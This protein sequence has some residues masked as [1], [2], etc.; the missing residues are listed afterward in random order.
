[1]KAF[2]MQLTLTFPY[3]AP[4]T[5]I[6]SY[7]NPKLVELPQDNVLSVTVKAFNTCGPATVTRLGN[8]EI[9]V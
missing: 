7:R 1:M 9:V 6:F 2:I 4:L 8:Q 5:L 3:F